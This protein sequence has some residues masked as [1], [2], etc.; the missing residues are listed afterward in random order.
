MGNV[1]WKWCYEKNLQIEFE[2]KERK[3]IS[4][5]KKNRF[6]RC[7]KKYLFP[8]TIYYI[9]YAKSQTNGEKTNPEL[10][11]RWLQSYL[12][13]HTLAWL[14][15]QHEYGG[16]TAFLMRYNKN[17]VVGVNII[18]VF[19]RHINTQ[20]THW[21]QCRNSISSSENYYNATGC[22]WVVRLIDQWKI[23]KWKS[24]H[25]FFDFV[26]HYNSL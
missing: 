22:C 10:K 8:T 13:F 24:T 3:T 12:I 17:I 25:V 1:I 4:N 23:G 6:L 5:T 11:I 7:C 2:A 19:N 15:Q 20:P 14:W 21:Q 18:F 26:S 9:V 16:S